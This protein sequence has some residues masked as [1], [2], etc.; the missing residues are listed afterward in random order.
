MK[1]GI[2]IANTGIDLDKM[3]KSLLKTLDKAKGFVGLQ[4]VKE[5]NS[6]IAVFENR[7]DAEKARRKLEL[8]APLC[9]VQIGKKIIDVYRRTE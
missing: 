4:I 9:G 8:L 2:V 5:Y 7:K 6:I 3:P 1:Y